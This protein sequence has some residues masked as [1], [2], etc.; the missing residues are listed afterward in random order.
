MVFKNDPLLVNSRSG[1]SVDL[2]KLYARPPARVPI[3]GPTMY[4]HNPL[5]TFFTIAGPMLLAGFIEAPE[6][7][8]QFL[9]TYNI[10][11][12]E[13]CTKEFKNN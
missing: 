1:L 10:I 13:Q 11:E 12:D 6:T 4:T 8:L 9:Y 2:I 7:G 5:Y 3:I